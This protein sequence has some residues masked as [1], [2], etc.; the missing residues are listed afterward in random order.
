MA[1]KNLKRDYQQGTTIIYIVPSETLRD[2]LGCLGQE[3]V[4]VL[5]KKL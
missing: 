4:Q 2:G 5:I 3:K 1:C